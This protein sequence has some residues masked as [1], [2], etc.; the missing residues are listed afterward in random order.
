MTPYKPSMSQRLIWTDQAISGGSAK[1][2]IGG[3]ACLEGDLSVRLFRETIRQIIRSQEVYLTTFREVDFELQSC[4]HTDREDYDIELVDLAAEADAE[5][6]AIEWMQ[7]D[8]GL[9]FRMEDNYLY[10]FRLFKVGPSRYLWY[11]KIH[12]L[13]SDG[14][15]FKLLLNQAAEVYNALSRKT[16]YE[17][18]IYNYSEYASDDNEYYASQE[19]AADREFWLTEFRDIPPV[20]LPDKIPGAEKGP[21]QSDTLYLSRESKVALEE[22]AQR[23]KVSVFNILLALVLI[24]FSRTQGRQSIVVGIP[25]LNRTKKRYRS[26]AGVFMNLLALRFSIGETDTFRDLARSV[27]EKLSAA[28]RH[29]RYPYGNLVK[30]LQVPPDN[31]L[32]DLRLSYEDFSFTSDFGGLK[33]GATALSNHYETDKLAIYMRD[34]H[35]HGFDVRLVYNT[36]YFNKDSIGSFMHSL[37]HLIASLALNEDNPVNMMSLLAEEDRI[38]VLRSSQGPA[39]ENIWPS[40][41]AMWMRSCLSYPERIA[42]SCQ[43]GSFTYLQMDTLALQ[44]SRALQAAVSGRNARV[45]LL[46]P[47]SEKMILGMLGSM[48]GGFTYIPLDPDGPS[49]RIGFI[50]EDAACSI[51]LTSLSMDRPLHFP[52]TDVRYIEDL[53]GSP[54]GNMHADPHDPG[55]PSTAYIL[56]TSG[57]TGRP[58]GVSISSRSLVDYVCTFQDYFHLTEKE[59]VLQQAS[60]SFDTSVEEIFPVL[61][62]GGR[63]HIIEDRRDILQLLQTIRQESVTVLSTTPLVLRQLN[64][65]TM[66]PSLRVLISGGDVLKT[67]QVDLLLHQG[68]K[69]FNT[70]GPTEATVCAT[71]YPLE[72]PVPVVPI[73]RPI[74]NREVYVLDRQRQPQPFGVTGEIYLGGEGLAQGYVN[75]DTLTNEQFIPHILWEGKRL[76]RTGDTG[77]LRSDGNFLFTGRVDDQLNYRGYRVEAGEVEKAIL[78][79]T[80]AG[81]CLVCI[82]EYNQAPLLVAYTQVGDTYRSLPEDWASTVRETIARQLPSFMVPDLIIPLQEFPLLVSGKINRQELPAV[83]PQH[84]PARANRV[85]PL[86]PVEQQLFDIWMEIFPSGEFGV[87]DSF[88]Q[89]GGHSLSVM[90][91]QNR[92]YRHFEVKLTLHEL[93]ANF[94][95][96]TQAALIAGRSKDNYEP[97]AAGP[98]AADYPV[99]DGQRRLWILSQLEDEGRGYHLSGSWEWGGTLEPVLLEQVLQIQIERHE[100]L[101]T[102]FREDPDGELR[103]VVMDMKD[104]SFTLNYSDSIAPADAGTYIRAASEKAF[105][106]ANGP[107]FRAGVLY[108]SGGKHIFYYCMHHIIS[109]GWSMEILGSD[110]IREYAILA[111][112]KDIPERPPLRIQYKDFVRWQQRRLSGTGFA[113]QR[114]Y[115]MDQLSGELPVLSLPAD[116]T[117]PPLLT[118]NGHE[119][120]VWLDRELTEQLRD[121]CLSRQ[122]TLFMGLLAGIY[123]LFLRYSGAEDIIIGTPVL[124]REHIDLEDQIGFYVNTLALRVKPQHTD[125]LSGI[126]EKVRHV[127][128][129]AYSNQL[130]PF[131]RLVGDLEVSRDLS[132]SAIFDVMV[133]LQNQSA[134]LNPHDSMPADPTGITDMGPCSVMFDLYIEFWERPD[135]LQMG[136]RYN[137]DLYERATI[138]RLTEH[139]RQLLR[140]L[141]ASPG[142]PIGEHEYIPAT[143]KRRLLEVSSGMSTSIPPGATI[144]DM[145]AEQLHRTPACTA[146]MAGDRTL[147]Y[148]QL[149]DVSDKLGAWLIDHYTLQPE[150]RV[151]IQLHRD[152]WMIIAVLAV[153]KSG[154]AYVPIDPAYPG[155]RIAYIRSDSGCKLVLDENVL[156]TFKEYDANPAIRPTASLPHPAPSSLAYVIYTSGSTGYPKGVMIEHRSLLAFITW[157][158]KE[159]DQASIDTVLGVT[160]LCF[161]LS[162]FEIFYTLCSG[163][164]LRILPDALSI[165]Q[166]ITGAGGILLN[167]VPSVIAA[168]RREQ[169]DFHNIQVLNMAGEPITAKCIEDFDTDRMQIR[170]LYG[171]TED[172]TYSTS[173][174]LRNDK[175]PVPIGAPIDNTDIYILDR[176]LRLQPFGV[177]GELYIAGAGLARGYIGQPALTADRFVSHPFKQDE[178]LYRTGDLGRWLPEGIIDLSGRTDDQIKLRGHRIELG[179]VN[180]ALRSIPGISDAVVTAKGNEPG[181]KQLVAYLVATTPITPEAV[182]IQLA[183]V[184]P[185]YMVP[186]HFIQLAELPLT[187]N[188]KIDK[189]RL[190][191]P[192]LFSLSPA[193]GF[194]AP[195][196]ET[197]NKLAAIWEELLNTGPISITDDFFA[198]G[199]HSLKVIRLA[200]RIYQGFQVRLAMK[201]LFVHTSLEQQA[202]LIQQAATV[203]FLQVIPLP[204]RHAYPLSAAQ[205]RLWILHQLEDGGAA[206]NLPAAYTIKGSLDIDA[207]DHAFRSLL[208][209]H[210]IL[211]TVFRQNSSGEP[212]QMILPPETS[213]FTITTID[214]R[215]DEQ[216]RETARLRIRE[217]F[218]E[219]FDMTSGPLVRATLYHMGDDEWILACVLHHI[220]CDGWSM[221]I[222]IRELFF[223]YKTYRQ[224]SPSPLPRLPFQYKD[225]A[226]FQQE[227]MAG[228]AMADHRL[229]W[230]SLFQDELPVTELPAD[231][232]R[233]AIKSYKGA[234]VTQTLPAALTNAVRSLG[235]EKG[236]SPFI[237][238][239]AAVSA[240]LHRYGGQ[241]DMIIGIPV[242][243][244]DIPGLE[245]QIGLYVNTLALRLRPAGDRNFKDLLAATARVVMEA[246]EHQAYPFDELVN[247]LDLHRDASRNPLFDVMVVYRHDGNEQVAG[248]SLQGLHIEE[249]RDVVPEVSK[250][251]CTFLFGEMDDRCLFELEY[252]TDVFNAETIH[253]MSGHFIQLLTSLVRDP[254]SPVAACE[255]LG[256]AEI[257]RLL[258]FNPAPAPYPAN[259]TI[260]DLFLRQTTAAPLNKAVICGETILTYLDLH[261]RSD[262][263]AW[264]L[265]RKYNIRPDELVAISL[266][267][268]EN[269]IIAILGVLKSGAAFLPLDKAYPPDRIAYMLADSRCR[270]VLDEAWFTAFFRHQDTY[271]EGPLPVINSPSDLAYVI[272]T[273]GSTGQPKGVMIEHRGVVNL[274]LSQAAALGLQEGMGTLQFASFSFDAACYEI[275]NTLLSGGY[276]LLPQQETLLS[277]HLLSEMIERHHLSVAVLPPSYYSNMKEAAKRLRLIVSAGEPLHVDA[278]KEL[279]RHGIRLVNAYGPTESTVCATLTDMPLL[280]DNRTTIGRPI[281]NTR[282]YILDDNRRLV[283]Q[284]VPGHLYIAGIQLARGYLHKETLTAQRFVADPFV[285]GQRMYHTGDLARWLEDGNI[286]FLGRQDDQLKIRGYRIEAG[287]IVNALQL[288]E[289]VVMA[290]V[291]AHSSPS[292][293]KE[294]VAYFTGR[295]GLQAAELTAWLHQL[296]PAYMIPACFV[297]LDTIPLT[298]NGKL[299][300]KSLPDPHLP[301]RRRKTPCMPPRNEMEK[302]LVAVCQELLGK[303]E[304]GI[305]DNFFEMGGHSLKL[306]QLIS[307]I[308]TAFS[309][310]I[311]LSGMFSEPT[312]ERIAGQIT[313]ALHQDQQRSNKEN[314]V[315][316]DI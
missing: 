113:A 221:N 42:V 150:D 211:R 18:V 41:P 185:S 24:Y 307:K 183:S 206:Y 2:N 63:L 203:P 314:L 237:V 285:A 4:V 163:K 268:D 30:D 304:I 301:G 216:R 131:D 52:G 157:C 99:S 282:I 191:D 226:S 309:V 23:H 145:L 159:F 72:Q 313:F 200:N 233:P 17:P 213:G 217:A 132:R 29:Q 83:G 39:R 15:S 66:P 210:E 250:F 302:W 73:G 77:I 288:H 120:S 272:Y 125:N 133:V 236:S 65:E 305:T 316:I 187:P 60:I 127:L 62:I 124:G 241:P 8:F 26:T 207:M 97:V 104:Y 28:L 87:E 212:E 35:D 38:A 89:L 56:Y 278:A 25:V 46:L 260:V 3:Y 192:Q 251:D 199:G 280:A 16:D 44:L 45:A 214:L 190:P 175:V 139:Y 109:D 1:Y 266:P 107:L 182:R 219:R 12:H 311:S 81:D 232:L 154:A 47:R 27:R 189:S 220:I 295:P 110:I 173:Y 303:E 246:Y 225:Y 170:N 116:R 293:E 96:R 43:S 57:T 92:C 31:L 258:A 239:L 105:D 11:A 40:F 148:R 106:L 134:R 273:S 151:G 165:P 198:R 79:A 135:G 315:Q 277:S 257:D 156:D 49:E 10:T 126:L 78:S 153:L 262:R 75:N 279:L 161:D 54:A 283:P 299:D 228:P 252:N 86:T 193:T 243:G 19:A 167:T 195:R 115:W 306:A 5:A 247:H 312:I 201:E 146:I 234:K 269:M 91:L 84:F 287:E 297:Q 118:H 80:G 108:T 242:A 174:R 166:Y 149:H 238:L 227:R 197:E 281:A 100:I 144:V 208:E 270:I 202:L 290:A 286:E 61:G 168:L 34:Y 218:T 69:I 254:L 93:F 223:F 171:P 50:L 231:R 244:R 181:E 82:R 235:L 158:R 59:V 64:A 7:Q 85:L 95:I 37:D 111:A 292:G 21:A 147:T 74:T 9:A 261:E 88:F 300:R 102:V 188:G 245:D 68:I 271:D 123:S 298:P 180:N 152:E 289:S 169:V 248:R 48:I 172:T 222:V 256:A 141:V 184:L 253:R 70:Y 215:Q 274:S 90:Q 177:I 209:R 71:Y 229:Y 265:L 138:I 176:N 140:L 114:T 22:I 51:L 162:I 164:K 308:H 196:N 230:T 143:E 249:N 137:S 294:L 160:S 32:Y 255:Y 121:C 186:R 264:C 136:I 103:Q 259:L 122:S 284:G 263:L 275:F 112:G 194:T 240:L 36:A 33:A 296:L 179:E 267:R 53:L 13:I 94:T 20:L 76:Y 310:R 178:R 119:L 117:R 58:K 129:A 276:L 14:M 142:T 67:E 101:R 55:I 204:S 98:I 224:A 6:N 205:R 291:I 130:Y 128:L 155:M